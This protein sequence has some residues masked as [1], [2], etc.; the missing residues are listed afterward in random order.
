MAISPSLSISM[1]VA[2]TTTFIITPF[3]IRYFRAAGLVAIDVHKKKKPLLPHSLG[4][5]V[6]SGLITGLSFYVFVHVFLYRSTENLLSIFA[7][8]TTILII[9]VIGFLD[10]I[11]SKPTNVKNFYEGK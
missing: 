2:F 3:A 7:S 11:N 5:S 6:A 8:L 9:T 1:L 10:D 4:L